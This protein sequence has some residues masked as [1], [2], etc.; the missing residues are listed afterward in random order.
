M[1][2]TKEEIV[3]KL[4]IHLAQS[5]IYMEQEDI[6]LTLGWR[7]KTGQL[8]KDDKKY[9]KWAMARL[10]SWPIYIKNDEKM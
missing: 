6:K 8:I 3:D 2:F 5:K 10:K 4:I 1:K 7:L 9:I